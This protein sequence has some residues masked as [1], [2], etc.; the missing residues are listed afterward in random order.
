[1]ASTELAAAIC[2]LFRIRANDVIRLTSGHADDGD[3]AWS[4]DGSTI[5]FTRASEGVQ[6]CVIA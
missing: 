6:I 1:V 2:Y 5:A 4:P 3:P